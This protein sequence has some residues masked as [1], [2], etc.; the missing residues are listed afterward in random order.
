MQ[1]KFRREANRFGGIVFLRVPNEMVFV[2]DVY[3]A[4]RPIR[5]IHLHKAL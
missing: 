1:N 2:N 5:E 3:T 4:L